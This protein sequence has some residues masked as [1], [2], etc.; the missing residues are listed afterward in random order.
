ML[1]MLV[2]GNFIYQTSCRSQ[3]RGLRSVFVFFAQ[4][5]VWLFTD[6]W[7]IAG[8]RFPVFPSIKYKSRATKVLSDFLEI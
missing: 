8:E 4:E 3:L 6:L 5:R 7:L 2:I 1:H